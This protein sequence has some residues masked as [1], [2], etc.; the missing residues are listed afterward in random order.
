M[1]AARFTGDPLVSD[2]GEMAGLVSIG[3]IV[4]ALLDDQRFAIEQLEKYITGV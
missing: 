3:D 2:N 1:T 4:K